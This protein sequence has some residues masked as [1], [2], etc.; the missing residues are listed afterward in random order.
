MCAAIL[1]MLQAWLPARWALVGGALVALKFG[2]ASYWMNSYWGG[3]AAAT[4]GALVLGAMPRLVRWGRVRDAMMLGLGA[5]ILANTRPYEGLI[6]CIPVAC[7]FL[8]W[9]AGKTKSRVSAR[10]RMVKV[11]V[12][13]A[14]IFV[15]TLTFIAYYN[16]RLT[17]NAFLTPHS[18]HDQTYKSMGDFLW[19]HPKPPRQ[20]NNRQFEDLYSKWEHEYYDNSWRGVWRV[21]RLKVLDD[22]TAYLWLGCLL[23]CPVIPW[24]LRDRRMRLP[25]IVLSCSTVGFLLPIWGLPHY[26][27]P[28]TCVL[29]LLLVQAIRHMRTMQP[30]GRPVGLVLSWAV[31]F[32]LAWDIGSYALRHKCSPELWTCNGVP[33]RASIAERLAHTP[34]KHLLMVRYGEHHDPHMEWVYNG[35]EIDSAKILWAREL[36]SVQNAKLLAYFKDRKIWLIE[37]DVENIK[38]VPYPL[39]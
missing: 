30:Y 19:Q 7:W 16:W 23:L 20:Y 29:F 14:A 33:G 6:F 36:D 18:L 1:W 24:V 8:W 32:L 38:L 21:S 25:L 9:L 10:D 37:P 4:G 34:G 26:I 13:V 17:G 35:A 11:F 22:R 15:V 31:F 27:A 12:P 3:A 5:A 2:I 39:L 28:L